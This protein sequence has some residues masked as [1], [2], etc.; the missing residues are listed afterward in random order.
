MLR[1]RARSGG[2]PRAL[3]GGIPPLHFHYGYRG[4]E[5]GERTLLKVQLRAGD[6]AGAGSAIAASPPDEGGGKPVMA[7][8]VPEGLRVETPAL[9]I[10][11]LHEMSWRIA[12]ERPGDYEIGIEIG[13]EKYTKHLLV[14]SDVRRLSPIRVDTSFLKQV[15]YPAEAPLPKRAPVEAIE[16]MYAA[17]A[18]GILGWETHWMIVFF[19]LVIVFAFALKGVFRVTI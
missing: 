15:I 2:H 7:L 1:A 13:G 8:D 16:V 5:P 9:W 11:S 18:V 10:P 14:T 3:L 6:E 12:A 17:G 4:L 19:V